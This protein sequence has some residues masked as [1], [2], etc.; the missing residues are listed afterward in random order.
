[1]SGFLD[2]VSGGETGYTG[3]DAFGVSSVDALEAASQQPYAV[4]GDSTPWWQSVIKYGATRAIDN[5]FGPTQVN[6]NVQPGS[7]AGQNGRTYNNGSTPASAIAA[8][9]GV[10]PQLVLMLAV[11]ALA[12]YLVKKG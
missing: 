5:R 6:G 8:S 10:S 2:Y 12:L 9:L 4:N 3:A 1:M 7:F 11:G